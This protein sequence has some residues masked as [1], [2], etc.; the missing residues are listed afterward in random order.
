MKPNSTRSEL[1]KI[2]KV[3]YNYICKYDRGWYLK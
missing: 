1:M 3:V 2:D